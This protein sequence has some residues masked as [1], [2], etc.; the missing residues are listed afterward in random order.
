MTAAMRRAT[1][2]GVFKKLRKGAYPARAAINF[3]MRRRFGVNLA[4]EVSA[5]VRE[6]DDKAGKALKGLKQK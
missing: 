4:G 5:G 1:G 2:S 6:I 3:R